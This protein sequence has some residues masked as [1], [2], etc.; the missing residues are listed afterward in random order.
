MYWFC[1][2][3][4]QTLLFNAKQDNGMAAIKKMKAVSF[5]SVSTR[6]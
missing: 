3:T 2:K 6:E 1:L 5:K 4:E